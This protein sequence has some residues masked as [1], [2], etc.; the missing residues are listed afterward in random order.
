MVYKWILDLVGTLPSHYEN[1]Q[2]Y[3]YVIALVIVFACLM[4]FVRTFNDIIINIFKR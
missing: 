2:L 1:W 3:A 4:F